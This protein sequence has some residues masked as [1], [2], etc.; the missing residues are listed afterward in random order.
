MR[1]AHPELVHPGDI[2]RVPGANGNW[3][4]RA[5]VSNSPG[6]PHLEVVPDVPGNG[7]LDSIVVVERTVTVVRC[8]H[9]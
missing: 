9:Q 1:S 3:R 4:V 2:V 5:L 8:A 7:R 6:G